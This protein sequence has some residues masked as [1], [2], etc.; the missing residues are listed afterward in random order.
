MASIK[1][2]SLSHQ[3]AFLPHS[4]SR[5]RESISTSTQENLK[6]VLERG[7]SINRMELSQCMKTGNLFTNILLEQWHIT[8]FIL[9]P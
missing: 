5:I 3:F 8:T 9:Q 1:H 4:V 7:T 6:T 2:T